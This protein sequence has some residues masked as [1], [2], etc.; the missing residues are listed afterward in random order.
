MGKA[1]EK[2]LLRNR[3]VSNE[4]ARRKL[5]VLGQHEGGLSKKDNLRKARKERCRARKRG[6][7]DGLMLYWWY[8]GFA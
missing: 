7:Q 6:G 5:E 3:A 2:K 8:R 4:R 1:P